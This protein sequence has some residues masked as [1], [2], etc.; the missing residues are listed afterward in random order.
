MTYRFS[1]NL[2]LWIRFLIL[3]KDLNFQETNLIIDK[4]EEVSKILNAYIN[5]MKVSL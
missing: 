2:S 1:I 5:K 4:A 3:I